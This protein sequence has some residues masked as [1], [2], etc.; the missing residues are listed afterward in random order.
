MA[1]ILD[2]AYLE[3]AMVPA[4][5]LEPGIERAAGDDVLGTP[6]GMHGGRNI[7]KR[8]GQPI[9]RRKRPAA[10]ARALDVFGLQM[11]G[12]GIDVVGVGKHQ[13][14]QVLLKHR[15]NLLGAH[16]GALLGE[17]FARLGG[18]AE[19]GHAD[20]GQRA[21]ALAHSGRRQAGDVA[22]EGEANEPQIARARQ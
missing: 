13:H 4:Q 22:A 14:P 6:D 16:V 19:R 21:D 2:Q 1:G 12:E 17:G 8:P 15:G 9:G 20:E 18:E 3:L 10:K 7:S 5:D 11:D